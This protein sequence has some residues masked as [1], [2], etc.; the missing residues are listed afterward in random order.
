M[1][2]SVLSLLDQDLDLTY[3][4]L[5]LLKQYFNEFSST[6]CISNSTTVRKQKS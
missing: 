3:S 5:N 1:K 2:I 4:I 6:M